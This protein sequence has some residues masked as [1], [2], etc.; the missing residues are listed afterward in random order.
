MTLFILTNIYPSTLKKATL[1][2]FGSFKIMEWIGLEATI[3]SS[4]LPLKHTIFYV[5]Q[6][7]E[8]KERDP[9]RPLIVGVVTILGFF[10]IKYILHNIKVLIN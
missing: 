8:V 9:L 4:Q 1:S 5:L 6:P 3:W 7:N 10:S 2:F